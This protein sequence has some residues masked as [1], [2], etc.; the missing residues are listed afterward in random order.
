VLVAAA[1]PRWTGTAPVADQR[2]VTWNEFF[3]VLTS[4]APRVRVLRVPTSLATAAAAVGGAVLSRIGPT[5]VSV[6]TVRGWNLDPAG[7]R[8]PPMG[9]ARAR[10]QVSQRP[11]RH[12]G[13]ARRSGGV[14]VASLV[15]RLVVTRGLAGR[16]ERAS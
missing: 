6:D 4:Y 16:R 2:N 10:A 1:R 8:H 13:H 15:G 12:P 7:D 9:G 3:D 11:D 5:L 14:P